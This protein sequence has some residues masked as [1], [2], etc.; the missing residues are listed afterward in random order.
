MV[1]E[2]L[3][4]GRGVAETKEHNGWFEESKWG[5]EGSLPLVFLSDAYVVIPPSYIELGEEVSVLHVIDER[6]NEREGVGVSDGVTVE[7]SVV[8]AEA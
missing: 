7:I 5:D 6:G 3:E 1:H 8:L 2:S 4:G